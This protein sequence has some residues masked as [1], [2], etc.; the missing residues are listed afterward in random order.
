MNSNSQ[1][2]SKREE[3]VERNYE[4]YRANIKIHYEKNKRLNYDRS[5]GRRRYIT[6]TK[7]FLAMLLA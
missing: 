5:N 7:R 3:W 6:E 1:V 2:K 4:S